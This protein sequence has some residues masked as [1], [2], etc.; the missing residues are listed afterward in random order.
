MGCVNISHSRCIST[1]DFHFYAALNTFLLRLFF[2]YQGNKM[3]AHFSFRVLNFEHYF[4]KT[5]LCS[6]NPKCTVH[7]ILFSSLLYRCA[8]L[9]MIF[10]R[11]QFSKCLTWLR[12]SSYENDATRWKNRLNMPS[13]HT[14]KTNEEWLFFIWLQLVQK[15]QIDDTCFIFP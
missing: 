3:L 2:F 5:V 10:K 14:Q 13:T 7:H 8:H 1:V 12:Q 4:K 6:A 15:E 9:L 11:S